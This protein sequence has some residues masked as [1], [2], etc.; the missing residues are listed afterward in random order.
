MDGLPL[1]SAVVHLPLGLA[2]LTPL[3]G[4]GFAWA[5]WTGRIGV[6]AWWAVVALQALLVYVHGAASAYDGR[7]K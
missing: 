3:L 7:A 6:N 4:A 1:R 5:V 2:V